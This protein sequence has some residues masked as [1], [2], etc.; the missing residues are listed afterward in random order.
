MG[1]RRLIYKKSAQELENR[2]R[3][4]RILIDLLTGSRDALRPGVSTEELD[5][6]ER[7]DTA[8][9]AAPS[10]KGCRG[11][12]ASICT[13]RSDVIVH[14]IPGSEMAEGGTSFRSR[15]GFTTRACT[16]ISAWTFSVGDVSSDAAELLKV[17]EHRLRRRSRSAGREPVSATSASPSGKL[18]RRRA[19]RP[20][21]N[22]RSWSG[23][24]KLHE[25]PQKPN[26]GP[27]G[28][29][30]ALSAGMT[31]A[32]EPIINA[33]GPST[34]QLE[35]GWTIVRGDGSLS[36]YFEHTGAITPDGREMLT[37]R[38]PR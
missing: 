1:K 17:T 21:G 23:P 29:C 15:P 14:G 31:I 6:A 25:E 5:D 24:R 26:Y 7:F 18:P 13:S 37:L 38:S 4:R 20:S 28:L 2:R 9:G 22:T 3:G 33:G 16:S 35:D 12:P 32:I 36:A 11:F 10:F 8:A 34:R 30:G 27:P 19:P